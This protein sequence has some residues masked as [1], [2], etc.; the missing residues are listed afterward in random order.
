MLDLRLILQLV[1]DG[2]DLQYADFH[3]AYRSIGRFLDQVH[4]RKRIHSALD[5]L[6]PAEF[7]ANWL[8]RQPEPV[9]K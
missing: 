7:E 4:T 8:M 2:F 3:D 5:Y 6:T 9:L 1:V